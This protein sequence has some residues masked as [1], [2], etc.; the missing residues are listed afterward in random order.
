MKRPTRELRISFGR[1]V[2]CPL[3]M[4]LIRMAIKCEGRENI[5]SPGF[6]RRFGLNAAYVGSF[7]SN[8]L[9]EAWV[10]TWLEVDGE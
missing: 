7:N 5:R 1:R 2:L 10:D 6:W 4:W 9:F 8:G 3:A